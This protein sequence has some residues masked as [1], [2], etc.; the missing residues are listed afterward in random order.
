MWRNLDFT[1]KKS[2]G[3]T[4]NDLT[5]ILSKGCYHH[6]NGY[7]YYSV[8]DE[9]NVWLGYLN[10]I[11]ATPVLARANSK[12]YLKIPVYNNPNGYQ[13]THPSVLYFKNGW[14]GYKFWMGYT[15]YEYS[16]ELLENPSVAASNDGVNWEVPTGLTNPLEATDTLDMHYSDPHLVFVNSQIEYWYRKKK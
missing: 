7:T 1:E 6:F 2:E 10:G 11:D 9:N 8:Y 4:T 5:N 16:N 15:P 12:G 14:N 3:A 13:A